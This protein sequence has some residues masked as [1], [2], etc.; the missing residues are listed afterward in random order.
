MIQEYLETLEKYK[1]EINDNMDKKLAE[2]LNELVRTG[3]ITI[4]K[5]E[6]TKET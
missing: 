3:Q 6:Q 5:Q 1:K 2:S 4:N